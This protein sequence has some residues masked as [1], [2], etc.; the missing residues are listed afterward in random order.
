[1]R[2][3]D[4]VKESLF[5]SYI[6]VID[7]TIDMSD[8]EYVKNPETGRDIKVGG[9]TYVRLMGKYHLQTAE[10]FVKKSPHK[11]QPSKSLTRERIQ[12]ISEMPVH[13]TAVESHIV[14]QSS[15]PPHLIRR[16][17]TYKTDGRGRPTRGWAL[18]APKKGTERHQLKKECGDKCFLLPETEG[19]PICPKCVDATCNCQIDCR[20]L[21]AAKMRAHQYKYTDLY[22]NIDQLMREK[23]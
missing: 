2:S 17:T 4:D 20:G 3:I 7:I 11:R 6:Y 9:P 10:R 5:E 18:D 13:Q 1:M 12:Q 8:E 23:C 22:D 14:E 16:A 15:M 19:F 21:T